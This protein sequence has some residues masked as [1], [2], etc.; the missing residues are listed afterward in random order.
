MRNMKRIWLWWRK[1]PTFCNCG[2]VGHL[3]QFCTK[4]CT[5]CGC[6]HN[7]YHVKEDF[8]DLLAMWDEK[9]GK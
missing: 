5:L 1:P 7:A 3:S 2:K 8:L 9:N 6:C 4:L